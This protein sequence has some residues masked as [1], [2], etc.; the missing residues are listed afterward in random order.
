MSPNVDEHV[1]VLVSGSMNALSLSGRD[2]VLSAIEHAV[3]FWT[4]API[5]LGRSVQLT[6]SCTRDSGFGTERLSGPS[7]RVPAVL[8]L[9]V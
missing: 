9:D 8:A 2:P 4:G 1:H 3:R 7:K 6:I 5:F